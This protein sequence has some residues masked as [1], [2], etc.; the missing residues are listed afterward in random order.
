MQGLKYK[1][2]FESVEIDGT[3]SPMKTTVLTAAE[4]EA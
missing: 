1:V 2:A 3:T 4:F